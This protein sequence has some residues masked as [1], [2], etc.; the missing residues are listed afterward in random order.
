MSKMMIT[1][2]KKSIHLIVEEAMRV[3]SCFE[4]KCDNNRGMGGRRS[5]PYVL[6]SKL[7]QIGQIF[8]MD[9]SVEISLRNSMKIVKI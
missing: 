1:A 8:F 9:E 6:Q 2:E 7:P 4:F 5:I 3:G